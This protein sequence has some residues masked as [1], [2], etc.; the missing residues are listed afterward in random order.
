VSEAGVV[1]GRSRFREIYCAVTKEPDRQLPDN[2]PC[3]EALARLD[4]EGPPFSSILKPSYDNLSQVDHR[5]DSKII[6]YDQLITS[7]LLLDY[8]NEDHW[9]VA[10]PLNW[11]YPFSASNFVDK[12]TFSRE[13]PAEA[14]VRFIEDDLNAR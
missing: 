12:Y 3:D 5:N 8:I 7:S 4:N 13:I 11:N 2:R 14:I 10:I 1:D 6:Y 9:A